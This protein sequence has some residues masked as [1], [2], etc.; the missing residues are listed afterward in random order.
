MPFAPEVQQ[1]IEQV[2][3]LSERPAHVMEEAQ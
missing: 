2:E 1:L 3:R